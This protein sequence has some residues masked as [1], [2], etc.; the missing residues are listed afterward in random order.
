MDA[1][2]PGPYAVGLPYQRSIPSHLVGGVGADA[3]SVVDHLVARR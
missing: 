1:L 2:E 3:R